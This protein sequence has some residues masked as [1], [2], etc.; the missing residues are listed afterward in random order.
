LVCKAVPLLVSKLTLSRTNL[1]L[2]CLRPSGQYVHVTDLPAHGR[3]SNFSLFRRFFILSHAESRLFISMHTR[4]ICD[5]YL[6][7]HV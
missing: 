1:V 3:V 4:T 5:T 2:D 6:D 7:S